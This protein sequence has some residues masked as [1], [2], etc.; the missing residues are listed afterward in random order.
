MISIA[1][2]TFQLANQQWQLFI[3]EVLAQIASQYKVEVKVQFAEPYS[4][5]CEAFRLIEPEVKKTKPPPTDL[6]EH[7]KQV[8]E[9][10]HRS[11]AIDW[12]L[13]YFREE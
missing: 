12:L 8:I 11:E 4:I 3:L 9:G 7:V 13:G 2:W 5:I 6:L 1:R 10:N